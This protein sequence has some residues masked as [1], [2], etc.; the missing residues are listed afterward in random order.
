MLDGS[1]YDVVATEHPTSTLEELFLRIVKESA[2]RPG[3]R[4]LS[5]MQRPV[6]SAGGPGPDTTSGDAPP[7]SS[8]EPPA[9][10]N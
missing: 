5:D 1:H 2:E 7:S 6:A 3:R 10:N 8:E 4:D 9:D